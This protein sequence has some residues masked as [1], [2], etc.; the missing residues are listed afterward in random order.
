MSAE[1]R[2]KQLGMVLPD[3]P[4]PKGTLP[5]RISVEITVIMAVKP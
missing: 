2:L 5:S 4:T 3:L 1:A